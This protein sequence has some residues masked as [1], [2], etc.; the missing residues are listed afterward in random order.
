MVKRTA[1]KRIVLVKVKDRKRQTLEELLKRHVHKDSIIHSDCWKAY[2][3]LAGIF[4]SH[5]QVNHSVS[6]VDP[7]TNVHTNTIEGN[8]CGVKQQV[9]ST[10]RTKTYID[11]YLIRYVLRH[12]FG[13][14][15][16]LEVLHMLL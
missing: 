7:I 9:S 12:N 14:N 3:K 11:Y 15:L 4:Q 2:S 6:F 5:L 8:W 16:F 10:L 13:T 1:S